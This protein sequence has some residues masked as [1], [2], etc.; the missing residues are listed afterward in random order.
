M[1]VQEMNQPVAIFPT[2]DGGFIVFGETGSFDGDVMGNHSAGPGI[3]D[4]W[5]IKINQTGDLIWQQC[6]GGNGY[7]RLVSGVVDNGDGSYV[8][9]ST[10]YDFNSGQ[11]ECPT[12]NGSDQVWLIK[13]TDTTVGINEKPI[14]ENAI[15]VYPNP[16][17]EYVVFEST[18]LKSGHIS[19]SDIYGRAVA[20][21]SVT[22]EKTVWQTNGIKPGVYLYRMQT[23]RGNNSGKLVI[24]P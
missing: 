21:I 16:A 13:V 10:I 8:I 4:I 11:V 22:A 19:V 6:F 14:T 12:T 2:G 3:S 20:Q 24:T 9:A 18:I 17:N 23:Q 15:N 7:D 1:V 5:I